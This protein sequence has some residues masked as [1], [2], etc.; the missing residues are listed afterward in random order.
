MR[1]D[2]MRIN[3][4]VGAF[5]LSS[6]T[7][8]YYEQVGILWSTHP[9]NKAQRY[10]GP[11]ALERLKQIVVLR[12]LQ[13]PIRD[14]AAIFRDDGTASLIRAFV[15]KLDSLDGE[16]AALTELRRLVRRKIRTT[17]YTAQ[18]FRL[19]FLRPF[20]IDHSYFPFSRIASSP[21]GSAMIVL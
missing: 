3:D 14:I 4:V 16:I 19:N 15:N 6:R 18:P 2:L 13:I 7:L 17:V 11:D 12:K 21:P 9:D 10:Y 1:M 20:M 8:R 5:G